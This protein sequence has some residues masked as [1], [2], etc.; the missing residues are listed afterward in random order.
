MNERPPSDA[1]A[2]GEALGALTQDARGAP[3]ADVHTALSI[4][5][6][7]IKDFSFEN[8]NAP[9][10]YSAFRDEGPE[11][12][13]SVDIA[14]SPL[15][16]NSHEVVVS[17]NVRANHQDTTAFIIELQYGAQAVIEESVS[18]EKLERALMIEVPR[19]VFPFLRNIVANATRDGGFPPLLLTPI[20]FRK[21]HDSHRRKSASDS[22]KHE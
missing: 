15:E 5:R 2:S 11:L 3:S 12:K 7:Y 10:I 20:N 1:V 18:E 21:I 17:L 19:L 14:A 9:A 8:P 13:I 6:Q 16:D 4:A 22:P